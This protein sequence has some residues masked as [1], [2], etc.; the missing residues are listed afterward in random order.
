MRRQGRGRAVALAW[1]GR[2]SAGLTGLRHADAWRE[3]ARA[4]FAA[5]REK[6]RLFL[7]L[8]VAFGLG[9]VLYF[10]AEREPGLAWPAFW[11]LV[12][13]CGA[14]GL[15]ARPLASGAMLLAAMV[16]AGFC[17]GVLR[18]ASITT[19]ILT[20]TMFGSLTGTIESVEKRIGDHRLVL[21]VH[22]FAG[23]EPGTRPERVRVTLRGPFTAKAGDTITAQARLLPP[24]EPARPGGYDFARDAFFRG[25]GAVG[26]LSGR[27]AI[28]APPSPPALVDRLAAGVE[29]SRNAL[30]DRIAAAFGGQAGAVAAA[31][32]TGKRGLIEEETNQALRAAGLYHIV[33]IS[34]LHMVLAA[35]AIFWSL[36]A[37]L[38][39]VPGLALLWPL[40]KIAALGAMAG[41]T[42]YS[43]FSG[44]E[45]ATERSLIMT[46]VMLGAI[47]VD[48][49]ALSLRNLAIAALIVLAREPET[50]LG[51]SFQM[52][53]AAVAGLIAFAGR[54]SR[55]PSEM[56]G[57]G[58]PDLGQTPVRTRREPASPTL[59]AWL[60]WPRTLLRAFLAL[61][62]TTFVASLATAPFAAY[63]FQV[64][65]PLG[66]FGNALALPFVSLVVMPAAVAGMVLAPLGLDR[67][68]WWLMGAATEP[69]LQIS[70]FFQTFDGAS[71]PV[72]A[73]GPGPLALMVAAILAATLL[74]GP[75]RWLA[76]P[77]ALAG[78]LSA[79]AALRP[80][81][82]VDR[83]AAGL[84]IRAESGRLVML[85]RPS[86]FVRQQWL[87]ADGDPRD[88]DD[89]SL[90]EGVTCDTLGCTARMR[91]GG[92]VAHVRDAQALLEDCAR[93]DI[94][95]TRLDAQGCAAPI[96]LDRAMLAAR[97]ALV[98]TPDAAGKLT[99]HGARDHARERPWARG[100]V[101]PA[102]ARPAP[103]PTR[104][105]PASRSSAPDA[106]DDAG[107]NA[108]Q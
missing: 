59:P 14:I 32:V 22:A 4:A 53:F 93:A 51:P 28:A 56:S 60:G 11:T 39:L 33:S 7:W 62:V 97:G 70:A 75:L 45:V 20:R 15:R 25:I 24:P 88:P 36:R 54:W 64:A 98:L 21:R 41:A 89:P 1:P 85:G 72:P 94:L 3:S 63:H 95:V 12:L 66:V 55:A 67:P 106:E 40:K 108:D 17:A 49:P 69:V 38:A 5:E 46:L 19:P 52:S 86:H 13:G 29:N 84:A 71:L 82:F 16:F 30:T 9:I 77:L 105:S 76:L 8:P 90:R 6:R 42:A 23:L 80:D 57:P 31:L 18:T 101:P 10:A 99:A 61:I 43:L 34:G 47:L 26:S 48:R 81:L 107:A 2:W 73:F 83:E 104:T 65:N 44:S 102:A 78:L 100:P 27:L 79:P 74:A 68:V 103:S 35:G 91:G 96:V 37:A 92:R 87:L 50:L 58:F